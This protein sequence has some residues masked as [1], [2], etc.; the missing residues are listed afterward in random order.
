MLIKLASL[1]LATGIVVWVFFYLPDRL[2]SGPGARFRYIVFSVL[3]VAFVFV[4][5]KAFL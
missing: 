4:L 2:K 1:A 3:A 5:L